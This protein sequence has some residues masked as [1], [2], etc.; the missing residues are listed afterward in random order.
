MNKGFFCVV[1]VLVAFAVLGCTAP[2]ARVRAV[3]IPCS[4][5]VTPSLDAVPSGATANQAVRE[6]T[7]KSPPLD[8]QVCDES[9]ALSGVSYACTGVVSS[10]NLPV[11]GGTGFSGGPVSVQSF[12]DHLR[13]SWD[14][15]AGHVL[16]VN[17]TQ[18]AYLDG[19]GLNPKEKT[20]P[21]ATLLY[22][23]DWGSVDRLD[24]CG[25]KK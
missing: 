16:I 17:G 15:T 11:E 2:E 8:K 18:L 12:E 19:L 21:T 22:Y 1:L 6:D 10:Y 4:N 13:I 24:V 7:P 9:V 23:S 25:W 14:Q 3:V 5:Y 20:V